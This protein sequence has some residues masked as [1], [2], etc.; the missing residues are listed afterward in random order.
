MAQAAPA[1]KGEATTVTIQI[2]GT[3]APTPQN[4]SVDNPPTGQV[5]FNSQVP[6]PPGCKVATAYGVTP[7][8]CFVGETGDY[9]QLQFGLNGP[10]TPAMPNRTIYFTPFAGNQSRPPEGP[11]GNIT[12]TIKVGSGGPEGDKK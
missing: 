4:S 11:A 12:G 6:S 2:D 8:N 5:N 1:P 3:Y 7:A 10:Y 9:L